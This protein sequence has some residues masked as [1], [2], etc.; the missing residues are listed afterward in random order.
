VFD[1][2][3]AAAPRVEITALHLETGNTHRTRSNSEGVYVFPAL[4]LGRYRLAASLAGFKRVASDMPDRTDANQIPYLNINGGRYT[5]ST[6]SVDGG[7]NADPLI[8]SD[9]LN[10]LTSVETITE[11]KVRTSTSAAEFGRGGGVDE[12]VGAFRHREI[13]L[14]Q[15]V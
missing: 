8:G 3:A 10:T 9:P 5:S 6:L 1:P 15:A 4:A 2:A 7:N 12:W 14:R 11:F 13:Q